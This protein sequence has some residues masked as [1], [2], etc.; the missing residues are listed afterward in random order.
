MK[1]AMVLDGKVMAIGEGVAI[2]QGKTEDGGLQI[3]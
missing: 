3:Q 2:I 1:V